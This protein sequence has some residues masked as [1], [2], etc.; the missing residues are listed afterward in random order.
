MIKEKNFVFNQNN[1]EFLKLFINIIVEIMSTVTLE[2]REAIIR[3][4]DPLFDHEIDKYTDVTIKVERKRYANTK[5]FFYIDYKYDFSPKNVFGYEGHPFLGT[6]YEESK[7]GDIV[8]VNFMTET[9]INYLLM[10]TQELSKICGNVTPRT[11][12]V[13]IMHA[14]TNF[15]D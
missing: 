14:L 4:Y 9:M 7:D 13:S 5:E 2:I 6:A 3:F 11:Y 12:K 15:W 8:A 10:D 1:I